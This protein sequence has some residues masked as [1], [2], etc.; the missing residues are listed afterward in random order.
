[1]RK[2]FDRD[3]MVRAGGDRTLAHLLDE[4]V[5]RAGCTKINTLSVYDRCGAKY[6]ELARLLARWR[7]PSKG[8]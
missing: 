8:T 2:Q 7:Q 4:I 6:E 5:A 3:A 1:M